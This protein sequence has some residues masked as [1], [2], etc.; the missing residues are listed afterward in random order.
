M[1]L[2]IKWMKLNWQMFGLNWNFIFFCGV[3]FLDLIF[4]L[5]NR[6]FLLIDHIFFPEFLKIDVKSPVFIIG[7]PRSGTSF[8]HNLFIRA[9]GITVFKAW[10]II[11]P[12]LTARVIFRPL[13]NYLIRKKTILFPEEAGHQ[14]AFDKP[15]EEEWLFGYNLDTQFI[16]I[17]TLLGF[18]KNDYKELRFCD[19]TIKNCDSV[20]NNRKPAGF[21]R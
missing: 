7:H 20:I 1:N 4:F 16:L 15:E 9:N 11:F 21:N 3:I 14:V 17:A 8:L 13:I 5:I 18:D 2:Y 10:H 19:P 6:F 12:A